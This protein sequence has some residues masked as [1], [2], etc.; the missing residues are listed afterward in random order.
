MT[1]TPDI[2]MKLEKL[3]DIYGDDIFAFALI[4]TK[5]FNS[6]KEVFVRVTS[7]YY[8]LP[9]HD[10]A[11]YEI[12]SKAYKV[13]QEVDSNESASTLTG[14]ELDAKRQAVLEELLV[15]RETVRT[16]VHMYYGDEL[17]EDEI[18]SIIGKPVK[19]VEELLSDEL[20]DDLK[21]KLEKYYIEICDKIHAEDKLKS[22]VMR[23]VYN[24]SKRDF[25]VREEAVP[26]HQ[27]T[28]AG[29]IAVIIVAIVFLVTMFFTI[30][31]LDGYINMVEE[32]KGLSYDEVGT[33]ESFHYTY[34]AHM[35][36]SD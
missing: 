32:E 10:G 19:F 2:M 21:A 29:K 33:N 22:Y 28:T 4:A 36:L 7:D 11:F 8:E 16:V 34:E 30:P 23:S 9:D 35:S 15:K 5:D 26:R 1:I 13:C 14:V 31:L 25:E 24:T 6:A 27:W 18:A 3:L 17:S 20:S 12:I